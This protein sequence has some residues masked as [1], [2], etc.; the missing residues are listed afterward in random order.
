MD[1]DRTYATPDPDP[2]PI[3]D[4]TQETENLQQLQHDYI[5]EE[6][7]TDQEGAQVVDQESTQSAESNQQY[8]TQNYNLRTRRGNW[9]ERY[10]HVLAN[11]SVSQGIRDMKETAIVSIMKELGQLHKTDVFQP[12][13]YEQLT[14]I[15]RSK[16]IKSLL[17]LKKKRDGK[18]KSRLV[19][20]G[21]QQ[22]RSV[23]DKN[24]SPTVSLEALLISAAID[25][26]EQRHVA[27]VDIEGAF[28]HADIKNEVIMEISPK[29][30]TII[31]QLFPEKYSQ[32]IH[33]GKLYV[34]LKRALYGTIEAAELF[35]DNLS[36]T[37]KKGGYIVNTYDSE[38]N[39]YY[40][41]KQVTI[42]IHIDDLK[43]SSED[44]YAVRNTV[45]YLNK[46]YKKI[47]VN[48]GK[49]HDYLGMNLDYSEIIF[50]KITMDSHINEVL[51][52]MKVPDNARQQ[53]LQIITCS[54]KM[55]TVPYLN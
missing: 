53:R 55:R 9:R 14:S 11:I 22:A 13:D 38:F 37:L 43:I 3:L 5:P 36:S 16:V 17:F 47:N 52:E 44:E 28:L 50:V 49:V 42:V 27:T 29:L 46:V 8:A 25:A 24:S 48:Y 18:L 54:L 10:A 35:Y 33:E 4:T 41:G 6:V 7:V 1:I 31:T 34:K 15:Q 12:V 2:D 45:E 21:S 23:D 26:G 51:K 40:R 30:A 39:K 19:A 32:Y 20:D